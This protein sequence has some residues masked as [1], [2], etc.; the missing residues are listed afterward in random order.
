ME[1]GLEYGGWGLD[2]RIETVVS[3][4]QDVSGLLCMLGRASMAAI[5]SIPQTD[6]RVGDSL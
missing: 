1:A 5:D 3:G 2:V 4:W 6:Q